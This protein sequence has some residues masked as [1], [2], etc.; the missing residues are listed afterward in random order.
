MANQSKDVGNDEATAKK[1]KSELINAMC[2]SYGL[3]VASWVMMVQ[4][5]PELVRAWYLF[6]RRLCTSV[7]EHRCSD[8]LVG[9]QTLQ[10]PLRLRKFSH[11]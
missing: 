5:R 9:S 8:L 7:V 6:N 4:A 1:K 3:L 10:D 2:T 11:P